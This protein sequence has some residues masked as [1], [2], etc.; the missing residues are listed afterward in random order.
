M[1]PP[2]QEK[3]IAKKLLLFGFSFRYKLVDVAFLMHKL[4]QRVKVMKVAGELAREEDGGE[5][6]QGGAGVREG[7]EGEVEV[8][9]RKWKFAQKEECVEA[10][11]IKVQI[12]TDK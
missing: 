2:V 10:D 5:G 7:E 12:L 8:E 3:A 6:V 9:K 4:L 1:Q 11:M